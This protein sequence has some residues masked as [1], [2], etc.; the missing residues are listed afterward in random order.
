[1]FDVAIIGA[2][3]A[4]LLA[5]KTAAQRGLKVALVEKR[6]DVSRITRACCQQLVM[7]E[8][9]AGD[10]V[11][12]EEGG[13]FFQR[14]GFG[15]PYA[16]PTFN[17]A[18]KYYI[19]PGGRRICFAHTDGRPLAV[20]FDKGRLLQGL[21]QGCARAG[22]ELMPGTTAWN[23]CDDR[24]HVTVQLT[25]KGKRSAIEARKVLLADGVNSRLTEALFMNQGRTHFVTTQCVIYLLEG[26]ED[27]EPQAMKSFMGNVYQSRA[28]IILYPCFNDPTRARMCIAR[29]KS[30]LTADVYAYARDK[31]AL[32]PYLK[33]ARIAKATGCGVRACSS[34][35]VPWRGNA[36]AIGDAA[37]FVEVET[38][39]ALMCGFYAATAVFMELNGQPG[40]DQYT[41]W[42]QWAF[43]FNGADA[44]RVA[45][46]YALVPAYSDDELDYLFGLVEAELLPGSYSQYHTPKYMWDAILGHRE[47][48]SHDR[49]E[50]LK[51]I[52]SSVPRTL[53]DTL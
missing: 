34:L 21:W 14:G 20:Q 3:P 48:I 23:A 47:Q 15:V 18:K 36:L 45:Q 42:W 2:G 38:Q 43:E 17:V 4:G 30:Q 5:A 52:E 26:V 35:Q 6:C 10:T 31:A 53:N 41:R 51:K 19:S 28:P 11:S 9:Y 27:P 13:I 40:F 1:M 25:R 22:V 39:G 8:G 37:A 46:G 49:P 7:D 29:N 24:E 32:A 16:G 44:L 33:N 50:L 12:V